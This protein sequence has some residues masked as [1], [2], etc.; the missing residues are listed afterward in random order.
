VDQQLVPALYQVESH[1]PPH[2][3]EPYKTDLHDPS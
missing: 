1:W 2:D 3:A